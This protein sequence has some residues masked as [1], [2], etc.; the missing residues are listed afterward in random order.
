LHT[1][2]DSFSRAVAPGH[3][4]TAVCNHERSVV[5]HPR[6]IV[7][8]SGEL[9]GAVHA[10][11]SDLAEG[12]RDSDVSIVTYDELPTIRVA[13]PSA[14]EGIETIHCRSMETQVPFRVVGMAGIGVCAGTGTRVERTAGRAVTSRTSATLTSLAGRAARAACLASVSR[15][16]AGSKASLSTSAAAAS[17]RTGIRFRSRSGR[18]GDQEKKTA[19]TTNRDPNDSN[20][21]EGLSGGDRNGH[22][23]AICPVTTNKV[24]KARLHRSRRQVAGCDR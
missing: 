19:E 2:L 15:S 22:C 14:R 1:S 8:K 16:A 7:R 4:R 10:P 21:H 17:T 13:A 9:S 23:I 12:V 3:C 11:R 6:L 24:R 20:A 18:T 5:V